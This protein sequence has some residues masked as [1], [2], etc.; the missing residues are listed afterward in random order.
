MNQERSVIAMLKEAAKQNSTVKTKTKAKKESKLDSKGLPTHHLVGRV[1]VGDEAFGVAYPLHRNLE[2]YF[3]T[4]AHVVKD[5]KLEDL[6]VH[7]EGVTAKVTQVMYATGQNC[8]YDVAIVVTEPMNELDKAYFKLHRMGLFTGQQ[9]GFIVTHEGHPKPAFNKVK[10][11][12]GA[13]G[14]FHDG[15]T[16][17]GDSGSPIITEEGECI[18]VHIEG[19]GTKNKFVPFDTKFYACRFPFLRPGIASKDAMALAFPTV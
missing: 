16:T 18:G 5:Q 6:D 17:Y 15:A 19:H 13:G 12:K 11:F 9:K 4:A 2:C 1:L 8:D 3:L 14:M 7:F 10:L